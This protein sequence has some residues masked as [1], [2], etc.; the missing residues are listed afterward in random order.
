MHY[1]QKHDAVVFDIEYRRK[2][3][4]Q[5]KF[6]ITSDEHID[7]KKTQNKRLLRLLD[8]AE[9]QEAKWI[10]NG[11]LFDCM[12]GKYDKRSNK[13]DILP[14]LQVGNYF[15]A[16][17]DFGA[18]LLSKHAKNC[19][20]MT[21]GN[22]ELSVL[23]RH[24]TDILKRFVYTMNREHG[25]K[26][27]LQDYASWIRFQF[28]TEKDE[29]KANYRSFNCYKTHGTGGN[30]PVTKGVIQSARRQDMVLADIY[31]SGHIH[32]EWIVSRPQWYLS[33]EGMTKIREP[34]HIQVGTMK[35][36]TK[37]TWENM[38]GFAPPSLG[39]V[40]LTFYFCP[41]DLTIK[42]KAERAV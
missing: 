24:E 33:N 9:R 27:I 18:S 5:K 41:D 21:Y 30:A 6:L 31:L 1:H 10:S 4:W 3:G 25:G 15:D 37:G 17:N 26:I 20:V 19:A 16:L 7:N 42:V 40:W 36:S 28:F 13:A 32:T 29:N 22:H 23:Q 2:R 34:L 8:E 12:G 39:G 11:D 14:E 38:K 35:D